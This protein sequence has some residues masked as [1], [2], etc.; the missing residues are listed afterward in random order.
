MSADQLRTLRRQWPLIPE[1]R[2]LRALELLPLP[3]GSG[4]CGYRFADDLYAFIARSDPNVSMFFTF[5]DFCALGSGAENNRSKTFAQLIG[6]RR[7]RRSWPLANALGIQWVQEGEL[8][9]VTG[10]RSGYS[11]HLRATVWKDRIAKSIQALRSWG[12]V[13]LT[14]PDRVI[15]FRAFAMSVWAFT[16][17]SIPPTV[18]QRRV[19]ESIRRRFVLTGQFPAE[20]DSLRTFSKISGVVGILRN[21]VAKSPAMRDD[22]LAIMDLL[23]EQDMTLR[24]RWVPSAAN[25]SDY[26]S[27]M[28]N[29]GE[30][31]LDSEFA[32]SLLHRFGLCTVDRFADSA[33]ALLPRFNSPFPCHGSEAV[34]AF[35]V[36][37]SLERSWVNPPWRLLPRIVS[38]L[39]EDL[40][41][42]ATLLV[43]NWPSS[44]WWPGLM[45]L[46]SG[47]V[48]VSVPR[49]AVSASTLAVD[50]GI[51]PEI[52]RMAGRAQNMLLVNVP[53]RP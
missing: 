1:L 36:S 6:V 10:M 5:C 28:P 52:L 39:R 33:S 27:R 35:S 22:L 48:P 26:F 19:M 50:M 25:P 51:V 23:E 13:K 47:C 15:V 49:T 7:V 14:V 17:G 34:E 37:W 43:P 44:S 31:R 41:A 46:A 16:A 4:E 40:D 2:S 30:W 11:G 8:M 45:Q 18:R 21:F 32:A 20:S 38:R 29:K 24:V 42:A 12:R 3:D 53:A 9:E